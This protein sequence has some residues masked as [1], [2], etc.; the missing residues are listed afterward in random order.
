MWLPSAPL[1]APSLADPRALRPAVTVRSNQTRLDA[2][3]GTQHPLVQLGD[4]VRVQLHL[5]GGAWMSFLRTDVASFAL[6]TFDGRFGV[7]IQ[8]AWGPWVAEG[9]W[10][11]TSA[12]LADGLRM[13][14][15]PRAPITWSREE[16][17]LDLTRRLGPHRVEVGG[18]MLART[19]PDLGRPGVHAGGDASWRLLFVAAD[20]GARAETDWDLSISAL[21]GL[22]HVTD[23][24]PAAHLALAVYDGPDRRGQYQG[25]SDRYLGLSFGLDVASAER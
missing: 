25:E 4:E 8:V 3:L 16:L 24:G 6:L 22:R 9:A 1:D 11:H 21:A 18:S 13:T 19:T 12:H 14:G 15:T 23:R 17:T 5:A 20:V 10:V 2:S 7:P